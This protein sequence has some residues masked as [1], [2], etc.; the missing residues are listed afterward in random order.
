MNK[1]QVETEVP[2]RVENHKP[3]EKIV[4]IMHG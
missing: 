3:Q 4:V 1:K 2:D